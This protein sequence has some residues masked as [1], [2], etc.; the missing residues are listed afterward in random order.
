MTTVKI[1]RRPDGAFIDT[2]TGADISDLI[3]AYQTYHAHERQLAGSRRGGRTKSPAKAD[4]ARR[5]GAKGGR[6]KK[7]P[8]PDATN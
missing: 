2:V 8:K 3:T 6:P 7:A 1:E 5:N 4:A